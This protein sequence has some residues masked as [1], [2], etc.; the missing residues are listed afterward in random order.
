VLHSFFLQRV[1]AKSIKA[2]RLPSPYPQTEVE[3][4]SFCF[5]GAVFSF[6]FSIP[7]LVIQQRSLHLYD[8][9]NINNNL[10]FS[11][12]D[13]HPAIKTIVTDENQNKVIKSDIIHQ[14]RYTVHK[15]KVSKPSSAKE[16]HVSINLNLENH[17]LLKSRENVKGI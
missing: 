2:T 10:V 3:T 17:K 15:W 14:R 12:D 11:F 8:G 1:A 5:N 16:S 6:E 13:Q 4:T 7:K 9:Q